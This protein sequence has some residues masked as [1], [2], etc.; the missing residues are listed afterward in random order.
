MSDS[1]GLGCHGRIDISDKF[2][3]DADVAGPRHHSWRTITLGNKTH[4]CDT[5]NCL[6]EIY[7]FV[8]V[9][10]VDKRHSM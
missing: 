3:G 4:D 8:R 5:V 10:I 7:N 2:Q 1:G 6:T 9:H